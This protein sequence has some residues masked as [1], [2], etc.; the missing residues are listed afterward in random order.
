MTKLK[1]SRKELNAYHEA[2]HAVAHLIMKIPFHYVTIKPEADKGGHLAPLKKPPL[3]DDV[4]L[5]PFEEYYQG[6]RG[7]FIAVAGMVSAKIFKT[8][9]RRWR[10]TLDDYFSSLSDYGM[11]SEKSKTLEEI[12][13]PESFN[14]D[15]WIVT[16]C[17]NAKS[18]LYQEES[19][20]Q[21]KAI[22]AGLLKHETL[23]Y[24]EVLA[25][26]N[27]SVANQITS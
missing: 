25:I 9:T 17:E 18:L 1:L 8:K 26:A 19:L 6:F 14:A 2:G 11:F 16:L 5:I 3:D 4:Q 10:L 20:V 7:D 15:T 13:G 22:A 24:Q 21:I 23:S 27:E 12:Y